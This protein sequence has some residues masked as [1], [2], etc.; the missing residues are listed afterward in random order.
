MSPQ[1]GMAE[2]ERDA[3]RARVLATVA[4]GRP[5]VS[6]FAQIGIG[7]NLPL[8]TVRDDQIGV[9]V[10]WDL[11]TFGQQQAAINE[12][13][14]TFA[15]ARAGELQA[16]TEIAEQSIL[17]YYELLRTNKLR[18]LTGAQTAGYAQEVET[19][20]EQLD[21]GLVT[22][23]D[24]RQIEARFA[25][26]EA[27]LELAA[28]RSEQVALELSI[29][30]RMEISCVEE[31]SALR[32]GKAL[33]AVLGTLEPAEA[34]VLAEDN[35]FF[36]ERARAQVRA[37]QAR[38]RGARRAG[39]PRISLNA[40]VLGEFDEGE[41]FDGAGFEQDDRIGFAM[42]QDLFASGRLRA[43]RLESRARLR[44]AT[45]DYEIRRQQLELAVRRA[46]LGVQ[47]QGA[48]EAKR[49]A[50]TDAARERLDTTVLELDRGTKTITD[51]VL[52]NED[53][54]RAALDEV[55]AS[56]ARDQEL[57]RLAS[58]TGVLL[59]VDTEGAASALD[60]P[61]RILE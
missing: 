61:I 40:F 12:A 59:E 47:R 53:F 22:R 48:V 13:R 60:E 23:S 15:A 21:R 10:N 6:S 33:S 38:Y 42:T 54:Y 16:R 9:R 49:R 18:E 3:A 58:L 32:M 43:G 17:L 30:T 4:Q 11:F 50:A 41:F 7:E 27:A 25:A 28:L 55:S 56:W 39:L 1:I 34:L 24:A 37:A 31:P 45:A 26:A 51:F 35:A 57:V 14:Q 46:V 29:L 20:G 5:Q 19:V 8:E 36:L 52:A 44:G 2:A